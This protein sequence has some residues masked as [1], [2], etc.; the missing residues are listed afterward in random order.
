MDNLS[1]NFEEAGTNMQN[2]NDKE[3][4]D[5]Q[6]EDVFNLDQIQAQL[7]KSLHEETSDAGVVSDQEKPQ[8][9]EKIEFDEP[10]KS[11]DAIENKIDFSP[12]VPD[13][14]QPST[15]T[16]LG[17]KKYVIYVEPDNINYME[18]LSIKDRKNVVNKIL[19]EQN[20][21]SVKE[22]EAA[23]RKK[24]LKHFAFA[25]IIFIIAFPIMFFIVN[26]SMMATMKN[27][28]QAKDNFSKLYKQQGKIQQLPSGAE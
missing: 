10:P 1:K 4:N 7:T 13:F 20:L 17:S 2:S 24:F 18:G 12:Q 26:T 8:E 6:F 28:Q 23:R 27:Y 11:E 16:D 21:L 15:D 5:I 14:A 3:V 22:K 9:Q 19:R 25:C